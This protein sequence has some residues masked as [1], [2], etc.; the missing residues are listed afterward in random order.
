[1]SGPETALTNRIRDAIIKHYPDAWVVK[2]HG[3]PYQTAGLPDLLALVHGVLFG[4]E[5]K[6]QRTGESREHALGRVTDRQAACLEQINASGGVGFVALDP[7]EALI[8][9]AAILEG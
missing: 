8:E 3:G 2:M 1:M 5:V 6:H 9:L 7:D 4:I